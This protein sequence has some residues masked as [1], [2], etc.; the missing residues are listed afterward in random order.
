MCGALVIG[1]RISTDSAVENGRR[2]R[3]FL[4]GA[5]IEDPVVLAVTMIE[6]FDSILP[7]VTV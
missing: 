1:E 5:K 4:H 3:V 7:A 2:V 6:E